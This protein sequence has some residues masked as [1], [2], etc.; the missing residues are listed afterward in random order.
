M[1]STICSSKM[2]EHGFDPE[3]AHQRRA[4][5]LSTSAELASPPAMVHPDGSAETAVL[6]VRKGLTSGR[7]T[8]VQKAGRSVSLLRHHGLP[9]MTARPGVA[10]TRQR[11]S[12]MIS[13]GLPRWE[14]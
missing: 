1:T 5:S 9:G 8:S 2:V 13:V 12:G 11:R 7:S 14:L 3:V 4:D 6:A 10:G